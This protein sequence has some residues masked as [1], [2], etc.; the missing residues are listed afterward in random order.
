MSTL[1]IHSCPTSVARPVRLGAAEGARFTKRS[2]KW[3][4]ETIHGPRKDIS[5]IIQSKK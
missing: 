1:K 4:G 2:V 5:V 3:L